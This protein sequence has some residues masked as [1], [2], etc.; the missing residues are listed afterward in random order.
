MAWLELHQS[1]PTHRKTLA[2]AEDLDMQPAHIVGHIACLWLWALDNAPDGRLNV[3]PRTVARAAQWLGE[4]DDFYAALKASGF[5]EA[6]GSLHDWA[7]YAGRRLDRRKLSNEWQRARRRVLPI[8]LARDGYICQICGEPVLL[9]ELSL[10]HVYPKS[11]GGAH[12]KENLRVVHRRCNS[13]K[14]ARV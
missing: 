7:A 2:M 3:S 6:D 1:L 11:R 14:G 12:T 5:V 10:D 8:V 9:E 13:R 4:P